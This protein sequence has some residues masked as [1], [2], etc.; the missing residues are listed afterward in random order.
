MNFVIGVENLH[1]NCSEI[2]Y[3]SIFSKNKLNQSDVV[4]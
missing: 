2:E 3:E 1:I 4:L